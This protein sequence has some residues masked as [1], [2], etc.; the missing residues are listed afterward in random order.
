MGK[1]S[2]KKK[3][4][5][6]VKCG[7]CCPED[8]CDTLSSYEIGCQK[9]AAVV[10]VCSELILTMSAPNA[11]AVLPS[12]LDATQ[13]SVY[14]IRGNGVFINRH[15]I[16][17]P[18]IL[19]IAPPT[20]LSG[21]GAAIATVIR[22]PLVDANNVRA[23]NTM[24][25]E[26]TKFSKILVGV[27]N[28][29]GRSKPSKCKSDG[30]AYTYQAEVVMVD[31]AGGYALLWIDD[32]AAWNECNPPILEHHPKACFG[33]SR[34]LHRGD[35]V[36]I[37]GSFISN[38]DNRLSGLG[39]GKG[40]VSNHRYSD[41]SG[42]MLAEGVSVDCSV[43][44]P[45]V[46]CPIFNKF[47]QLIALQVTSTPGIVPF[48]GLTLSTLPGLAVL[49]QQAT[50]GQ[51]GV[52]GIS[53]QFMRRAIK[54]TLDLENKDY[55]KCCYNPRN[56]LVTVNDLQESYYKYSKGY[57]G[58]A[59][60]L[61]GPC[62][63][64]TYLNNG[65][66]INTITYYVSGSDGIPVPFEIPH[67]GFRAPLFNQNGNGLYQGPKCKNLLGARIETLAGSTALVGTAA[68]TDAGA[69]LGYVYV[70]GVAAVNPP[71]PAAGVTNLVNSPL[72]DDN[73][74]AII[75][76]IGK[77][78]IGGESCQVPPA[79]VTWS[80]L[81]NDKINLTLRQRKVV[82]ATGLVEEGHYQNSTSILATLA[83]FPAI[84]DYPW[85]M[86]SNFPQVTHVGNNN[87]ADN[88][89]GGSVLRPV[90]LP[91]ESLKPAF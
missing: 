73:I 19:A 87:S 13:F 7:P 71:F 48:A 46:G 51:G 12:P 63:Y 47:G 85:F 27:R 29:N 83:A 55:Y 79:L 69:Q 20:A 70:P 65:T 86:I 64:N 5:V 9:G 25:A 44:F 82:L 75:D 31:G 77:C 57:L 88:A 4:Y 2:E 30:H 3:G 56:H 60:E 43:Q 34:K 28:L 6:Q 81:P 74:E 22:Y 38:I 80:C 36:T 42:W 21:N 35:D 26:M 1:E 32:C 49:N 17:V 15:L 41:P 33:N 53:E 78:W 52:V 37:L 8:N 59:Y 90:Q 89:T 66:D 91:V 24:P 45:S 54:A 40:V 14:T 62:D 18:S 23:L 39:V 11:P 67:T 72:S 10:D 76:T 61:V 16:L 58:V 84:M 50:I 68:A